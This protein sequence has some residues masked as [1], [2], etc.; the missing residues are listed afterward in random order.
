M[1]RSRLARLLAVVA[2]LA[3]PPVTCAVAPALQ[4]L[5]AR[6]ERLETLVASLPAVVVDANGRTLGPVLGLDHYS[7]HFTFVS[8]EI[9]T[10]KVQITL[11]GLPPFLAEVRR[12][13]LWVPH[14][15]G[16]RLNFESEDCTGQAWV[17]DPRN[18]SL[19]P[20]VSNEYG[21]YPLHG[22]SLYMAD[23]EQPSQWVD[24]RSYFMVGPYLPRGQFE[25]DDS[26][27]YLYHRPCTLIS[28]QSP[29][30]DVYT[31]RAWP[32]LPVGDLR[33]YF[34]PPYRL[35]TGQELLDE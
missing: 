30:R 3:V 11:D 23:L 26:L 6:T 24:V 12:D 25:Y 9:R 21:Y 34:E 22:T 16:L 1:P 29:Y 31:L 4:S 10:T 14:N 19:W 13:S 8:T 18:P 15:T 17:I 35:F 28:S 33:D 20:A 32:M 2:L 7:E 27:A 5:I